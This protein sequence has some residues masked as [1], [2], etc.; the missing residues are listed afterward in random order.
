[1]EDYY[2]EELECA[3]MYLDDLKIPREDDKDL[4]SLVGRIKQL[5]KRYLKQM[6]DIEE[7]YLGK[8]D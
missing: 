3:H 8:I 7:Y 1:M 5:E 2:K 4:F 6:S